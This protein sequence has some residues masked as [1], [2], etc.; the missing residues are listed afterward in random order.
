MRKSSDTEYRCVQVVKKVIMIEII[1]LCYIIGIGFIIE[2]IIFGSMINKLRKVSN[3]NHEI[4]EM[5]FK[6]FNSTRTDF[7]YDYKMYFPKSKKKILLMFFICV[8]VVF[9]VLFIIMI[10]NKI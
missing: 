1:L 5:L 6:R 7:F 2:I 10:A 8:H 9:T 3:K 4:V